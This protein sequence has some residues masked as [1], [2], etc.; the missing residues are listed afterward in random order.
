M[1]VRELIERL[2]E[3][4]GEMEV[5]FA[6]WYTRSEGWGEDHENAVSMVDRIEVRDNMVIFD[7]EN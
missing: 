4:D 1:K 6:D 2:S 3:M 7:E 5:A